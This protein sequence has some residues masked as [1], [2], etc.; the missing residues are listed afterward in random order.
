MTIRFGPVGVPDRGKEKARGKE[1]ATMAPATR[2]ALIAGGLGILLLSAG[3]A[4]S[5]GQ[6]GVVTRAMTSMRTTREELARTRG[7]V[8]DVL[9]TM[10]QF[11]SASA[12]SL[13]WV[14][15]VFTDQASQ[16]IR[17]SGTVR[18][19][20]NRMLAQ[21]RQ[22]LASWEREIV[23][24]ST[25][26]LR[27]GAAERRETVRQ[28][29]KC[30]GEAAGAMQ[31]AFPPFLT[32]LRD[33]KDYLSLDLTPPGVRVVQPTRGDARRSGAELKQTITAFMAQIDRVTAVSPPRK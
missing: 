33:I 2:K 31:Q 17:Q 12:V 22:Y 4:T 14:Y 6:A 11:G 21:W 18:R 19:L 8:D 10:D 26:E 30:L 32:Q 27:A 15:K 3:C 16:M 1:N 23:R 5:S 7:Q 20:T 29:Y 13:P 25:P 24:L 28:N 9:G